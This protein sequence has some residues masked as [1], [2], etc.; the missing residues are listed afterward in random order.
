[1]S[2]D[3][4]QAK[5]GLVLLVDDNSD[6]RSYVAA[7]LSEHWNVISAADGCRRWSN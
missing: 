6:M 5:E 4:P 3:A 2:G 7:L 1:V